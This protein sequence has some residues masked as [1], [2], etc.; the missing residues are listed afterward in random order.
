MGSRKPRTAVLSSRTYWREADARAVLEAWKRSG[1]SLARFARA[2]A[3]PLSKL[4]RWKRRLGQ[5]AVALA[6]HPVEVRPAAP[7][8]AGASGAIELVVRGGR[9]VAVGPG[10]DAEVL[11][12]VVEAVES[13]PC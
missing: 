8:G 2:R 12:E 13:W 10:F 5:G 11:R 3:I 1:L 9:R 7:G 6:F 4:H